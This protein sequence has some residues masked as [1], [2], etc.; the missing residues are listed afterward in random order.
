MK[1]LIAVA[2]FLI[3][4][5]GCTHQPSTQMQLDSEHREALR[6]LMADEPANPQELDSSGFDYALN[7]SATLVDASKLKLESAAAEHVVS[8]KP[9]PSTK[10]PK[11][12]VSN[13]GEG[14]EQHGDWFVKAL[15]DD[16]DLVTQVKMSTSFESDKHPAYRA[17][18]DM[19]FGFTVFNGRLVVQSHSLS[20]GGRDY[21][22]FCENNLASASVDGGRAIQIATVSGGGRCN[23]VDPDGILISQFRAGQAARLRVHYDDGAISLKGFT[24]AWNRARQLSGR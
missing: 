15:H 1:Y 21:W 6:Q 10:N 20:L 24:A 19:K 5:T 9:A 23:Q 11:P 7:P 8:V 3:V 14:W 22:P 16:M 17:S 2:A 12:V 13:W 18:D 4:L